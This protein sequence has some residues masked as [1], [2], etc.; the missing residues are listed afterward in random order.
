MLATLLLLTAGVTEHSCDIHFPEGQNRPQA[1]CADASAQAALDQ[2]LAGVRL[3]RDL[4]GAPPVTAALTPDADGGWRIPTQRLAGPGFAIPAQAV[5][6][7][8]HP[9]ACAVAANVRPNGRSSDLRV[10]CAFGA[11][12][13]EMDS[14][15]VSLATSDYRNAVSRWL[16]AQRFLPGDDG[17]CFST[18]LVVEINHHAW[19]EALE[20][21]WATEPEAA[22]LCGR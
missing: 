6:R 20:E 15:H 13:G 8:W 10:E 17:A 12:P 22:A 19:D 1:V 11:P 14:R 3:P 21:G 5:G 9:A 4:Q 2:R 7:G 16:R 18:L